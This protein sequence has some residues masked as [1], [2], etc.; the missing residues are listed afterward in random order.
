MGIFFCSV[1]NVFDLLKSQRGG[2]EKTLPYWIV[3]L[4]SSQSTHCSGKTLGREGRDKGVKAGG[5]FE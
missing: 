4:A 1:S 3:C 2:Q 5:R